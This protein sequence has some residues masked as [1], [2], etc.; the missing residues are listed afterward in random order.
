MCTTGQNADGSSSRRTCKRM[1]WGASNVLRMTTRLIKTPN[2]S[3]TSRGTAIRADSQLELELFWSA[4]DW[5]DWALGNEVDS[6]FWLQEEHLLWTCS[7]PIR[8][9][10][11]CVNPADV[12][13]SEAARVA[14]GEALLRARRGIPERNCWAVSRLTTRWVWCSSRRA[15]RVR[16]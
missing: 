9:S 4:V 15:D 16:R 3:E 7:F 14:N 2:T 6:T 13:P 8:R 11:T 10:S 12:Q 1:I 5:G